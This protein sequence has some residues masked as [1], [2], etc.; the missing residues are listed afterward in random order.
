M[1]ARKAV[2]SARGSSPSAARSGRRAMGSTG[3][4]APFVACPVALAP[5]VGD[6]ATDGGFDVDSSVFMPVR[7]TTRSSTR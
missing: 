1:R 4:R 3:R 7:Q 2:T 5:E 6:D